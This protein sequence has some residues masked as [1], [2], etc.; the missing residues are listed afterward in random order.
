MGR[1]TSVD[2]WTN[3]SLT[4]GMFVGKCNGA[5]WP[6]PGLPCGTPPLDD[7]FLKIYVTPG[8]SNS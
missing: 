3:L 2:R 4:C 1:W 8:E 7:W 5:T 6:S